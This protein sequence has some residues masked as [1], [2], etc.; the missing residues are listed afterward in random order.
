MTQS[1]VF[2]AVP[3]GSG[4]QVLDDFNLCLQA[5]ATQHADE[6]APNPAYPYMLWR[7]PSTAHLRMRNAANSAWQ[8]L[9]WRGQT[10]DPTTG[11]DSADGFMTGSIW[12]NETDNR[13]FWCADPAAGAAVWL[14]A[15]GG[16]GGVSSVFGRSGVV[17]KEAGDYAASDISD[18]GSKVIMTVAERATL[19]AISFPT[20]IIPLKGTD[21]DAD[22]AN[23]R[24]AIAAIKASGQPGEIA[25]SGDFKIGHSGDKTGIDPDTCA[26]LRLTGRGYCRW[27]K[28]VAAT[29]TGLTGGVDPG[30]GTSYHLLVRD[31]SYDGPG[32]RLTIRNMIF[33]G[34]LE[35]T[36]LQ[37]GD[38]A[39]L[40]SLAYYDLIEL[41]NVEGRWSSQMTFSFGYCN[42]VIGRGIYLHHGARDGFN[43]SNCSDVFVEGSTFE[44]LVDDCCAANLSAGA[45]ED[46]G[47]QRRFHFMG[48]RVYNAQGCKVLGGKHIL[49]KGNSFHVPLNYAVFVGSDPSYAEGARPVED[50][51][52]EGNNITD[53]VPADAWGN[54]NVVDTGI[55]VSQILATP[56]NVVVRGNNLAQRTA[57]DGLTWSQLKLRGI[58]GENRQWR[59]DVDGQILFYDPTL[60]GEIFLGQGK[61]VRVEAPNGLDRHTYDLDDNRFENFSEDAFLRSQLAWSGSQAWAVPAAAGEFPVGAA[62]RITAL[63]LRGYREMRLVLEIGG[64]AGLA[65]S[66]LS[67]RYSLDGG[68]TW[69][70]TIAAVV[71]DGNAN[72]TFWGGWVSM[73]DD[74]ATM[75]DVIAALYGSGGNGSTQV[76]V[77][78][79]LLD[80][81]GID[82][83]VMSWKLPLRTTAAERATPVGTALRSYTPAD[84]A[85]IGSGAART[86]NTRS[87][88]S[89]PLALTDNNR[90]VETT[91]GSAVTITVPA[92]ASVAFPIGARI[93]LAQVGA[94]Q[95]TASPAGGVTLRTPAG[96]AA[97]TRTQ[98]SI[99]ALT[100]RGTDEWIVSG[101]LA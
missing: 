27:R 45:A 22:N 36:M 79:F 23:I 4:Q 40:I 12:F 54:S 11:D 13:I 48:N 88:T 86:P 66:V 71:L 101:D 92:N 62:A 50:A 21:S 28:G 16:G 33:E 20:K 49:V 81:R 39:R 19:A 34:D 51:L 15:G 7:Q 76:E 74:L 72:Q 38:A 98:Y 14:Q 84:V 68:S 91:N 25:M 75:Y 87:T 59:M 18:D 2:G 44:W 32:R 55:I 83:S 73:P 24:A 70:D 80:I 3:D 5:L 63:D 60:V 10:A 69:T 64:N 90:V 35:T 29:T 82:R 26:D 97:K 6:S 52:I 85:E 89:Y 57:T 41:E 96:H 94:G 47:Q 67:W 9:E 43:A 77:K 95:I 56:H 42:R 53:L 30:D 99:I 61:A 17:V 100:K 93:E 65:G 78:S 8:I 1:A 37:L 31:E 58:D 46:L